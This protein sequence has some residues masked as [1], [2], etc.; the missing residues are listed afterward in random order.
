[1]LLES[2]GLEFMALI[3]DARKCIHG[4]FPTVRREEACHKRIFSLKNV[5]NTAIK[6]DEVS[7]C[8]ASYCV[9]K[10][11][12]FPFSQDV[13]PELSGGSSLESTNYQEKICK[14]MEQGPVQTGMF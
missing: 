2:T 11:N 3:T 4:C 6:W 12:L 5:M 1:M 8:S 7:F 9:G 13:H 14:D 10:D